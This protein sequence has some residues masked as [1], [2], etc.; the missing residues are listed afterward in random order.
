MII[1][2]G[3]L[4][5]FTAKLFLAAGVAEPKAA[6]VANSL[7]AANLRGVDSHGVQLASFYLEQILDGNVAIHTDGRIVTESGACLTYDGQNGIGQWVSDICCGHAVRLARAHGISI[8]VARESSH[9]GAAAFW[10]QRMSDRG[11]I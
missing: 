5:S 11:F 6:L 10:A 1:H 3:P 2:A 8:V 9:F 7:I 4:E